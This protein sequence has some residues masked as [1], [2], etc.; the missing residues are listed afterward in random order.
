MIDRTPYCHKIR[1]GITGAPILDSD[2]MDGSHAPG[3]GLAPT[4][5][6][7]IY[8]AARDGKP[9]SVAASVTG[10]WT[11]FGKREPFDDQMTTHFKNGT[12]GWPA[13]LAAEARL[14]DPAAAPAV[15]S[16]LPD[17]TLRDRIAAALYERERPPRDPAWAEAYAMDRETF[18]E[19]ADAVLAVLPPPADRPAVLLEA[20]DFAEE[21]AE[22]LRAHHEFE[23]ST[24]AL[25][26]MAEL[27]RL[28]AAA[29]QPETETPR[30]CGRPAGAVCVHDVASP[31]VP[32]QPAADGSGEEAGT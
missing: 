15:S 13:W 4:L 28:A 24:G 1:Y 32:V 6:E 9:P 22:K 14:H 17:Q 7:L 30:C 27:R 10:Q 18:E 3:V 29:Q 21:V 25:D 26:V 20:A 23:R 16:P 19:M 31:A 5:I 8:S 11:R 12:D 2:D